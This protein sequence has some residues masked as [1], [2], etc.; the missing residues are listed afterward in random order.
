M[1]CKHLVEGDYMTEYVEIKDCEKVSARI[2]RRLDELSEKFTSLDNRLYRDNG[3]K[4][5]Q[6]IINSHGVALKAV[7]WVGTILMISILSGVVK[8]IFFT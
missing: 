4:S 1:Y 3:R 6:T 8:L 7:L 5:I 2:L